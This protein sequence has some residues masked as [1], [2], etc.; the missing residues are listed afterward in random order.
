MLR[1]A[2]L[3]FS[4]FA[5]AACSDP[6]CTGT[7][8][9]GLDFVVRSTAGEDLAARAVVTVV[10]LDAPTDSATGPIAGT[11]PTGQTNPR[12]IAY[13]PGRYRVRVQVDGYRAF[14]QVYEVVADPD[15]C[16]RSVLT[17]T[18]SAVMVAEQ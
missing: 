16:G 13:H 11:V 17:T 12:L 9:V 1:A 18:V 15:P 2:F 6:V 14:E 4:A 3:I 10:S 5:L 8:G 7:G